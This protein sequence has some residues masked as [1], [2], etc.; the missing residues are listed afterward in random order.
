M[1]ED[2][3]NKHRSNLLTN[4]RRSHIQDEEVVAVIGHLLYENLMFHHKHYAIA[5]ASLGR[6]GLWR[7]ACGVLEEMYGCDLVPNII[8]YNATL[9]ACQNGHSWTGALAILSDM[10]RASAKRDVVTYSS[11]IATYDKAGSWQQAVASFAQALEEGISPDTRIFSVIISACSSASQWQLSL[12][13]LADM[14]AVRVQCDLITINAAMG[15][16]GRA[17]LWQD[18][19]CMLHTLNKSGPQPDAVSHNV[20]VTACGR[21]SKWALSL[22]IF[23]QMRVQQIEP[24]A[25]SFNAAIGACVQPKNWEVAISLMVLA[26]SLG[27]QC[28]RPA[29]ATTIG[30]LAE[31]G[32]YTL[33][34]ELFRESCDAGHLSP[35]SINQPGCVELHRLGVGVALTII[36][37]V[38]DDC[39]HQPAHR[40]CHDMNEDLMIITGQGLHSESGPVLFPAI[41]HFL[42]NEF[43]P[44]LEII[45]D[46]NNPGRRIIPSSSIQEWVHAHT[47]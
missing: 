40:Y 29:Y 11:L 21:E 33:A 39:L 41:T 30:L 12:A 32:K 6:R 20:V 17:H 15:A 43:V 4:L 8:C 19:L 22:H 7:T 44:P 16:V 26:Q 34:L 25:S 46:A 47:K 3:A 18:A 1:F 9:L 10:E 42:S 24:I 23:S 36:Y 2:G 5:L 45:P 13:L 28:K 38:L 27:F 37:A 35:W 31:A 14:N